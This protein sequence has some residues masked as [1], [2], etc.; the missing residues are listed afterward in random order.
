MEQFRRSV[1]IIIQRVEEDILC[2]TGYEHKRQH[3]LLINPCLLLNKLAPITKFTRSQPNRVI[4]LLETPLISRVCVTQCVFRRQIFIHLDIPR[5][6][7]NLLN[8]FVEPPSSCYF[9]CF[10]Q[11]SMDHP[12]QR[13]CSWFWSCFHQVVWVLQNVQ[14]RAQEFFGHHYSQKIPTVF[15][16]HFYNFEDF[17]IAYMLQKF[18]NCLINW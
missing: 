9:I 15:L 13:F 14:E 17:L 16:F 10:L 3:S 6:N 12:V 8:L 5:M 4:K 7:L 11:T 18:F 1:I 2:L